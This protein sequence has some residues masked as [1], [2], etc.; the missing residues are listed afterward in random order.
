MKRIRLEQK[1]IL[2]AVIACFVISTLCIS[3]YMVIAQSLTNGNYKGYF[4][5]VTDNDKTH[6]SYIAVTCLDEADIKMFF[7]NA[8][9][10]LRH[11]TDPITFN[12]HEKKTF[13]V[14]GIIGASTYFY[15]SV[16]I[17]STAPFAAT[18]R[19]HLSGSAVN[20]GKQL[21]ETQITPVLSLDS[22][23]NQLNQMSTKLDD[24]EVTT[25]NIETKIDNVEANQYVPFKATLSGYHTLDTLGGTWDEDLIFIESSSTT[26]DFIVTSVAV[27]IFGVDDQ[28]DWFKV[29]WVRVDFGPSFGLPDEDLTEDRVG[30]IGVNILPFQ[31]VANSEGI[32]DIAIKVET[33]AGEGFDIWIPDG[34]L[35]VSGW[36]QAGDTITVTFDEGS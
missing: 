34:H 28:F 33:S 7:Y 36:K 6:I 10:S 24:L 35:I 16:V 20:G 11:E 5:H 18:L 26:G 13:R 4:A 3:S 8:D 2:K 22:I 17:E 1:T 31:I 27:S 14:W 25:D 19:T 15:G 29:K 32:Y 21:L 23:I 30:G 9:G 12:P